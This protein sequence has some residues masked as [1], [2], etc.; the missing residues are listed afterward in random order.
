MWSLTT[1]SPLLRTRHTH[2]HTPS[3]LAHV[4]SRDKAMRSAQQAMCTGHRPWRP[5]TRTP[6]T[7]LQARAT[8]AMAHLW[9]RGLGGGGACAL[10]SCVVALLLLGTSAAAAGAAGTRPGHRKPYEGYT[11]HVVFSNHLVRLLLGGA[12]RTPSCLW[13]RET[14]ARAE[15]PTKQSAHAAH[16]RCRLLLQTPAGHWIHG[17]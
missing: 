6:I 5:Q 9:G 17:P 3:R 15:P 7:S 10:A 8:T 2:S 14:S 16:L 13:L 11:V 12:R 4:A 1:T